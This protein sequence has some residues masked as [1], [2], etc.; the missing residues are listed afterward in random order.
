MTVGIVFSPETPEP[1]R[2][3]IVDQIKKDLETNSL[4]AEIKTITD[5]D[6]LH[7][8]LK[9]SRN[10]DLI[11]MG[12]KSGDFAELLFARSL[13]NEI[14]EQASCPVLWLK[15]YEEKESFLI[16]LFKSHKK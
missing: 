8:I 16:S 4:D 14:T 15:E 10:T 3:K 5:S 12:G 13:T 1:A 7:G 2:Q 11:V 6:I 9:L